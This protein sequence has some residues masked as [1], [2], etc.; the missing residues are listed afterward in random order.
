MKYYDRVKQPTTSTGTGN[1]TLG[2]A[3]PGYRAFPAVYAS[4]DR[5]MYVVEEPVSGQWELGIGQCLGSALVR[6]TPLYGSATTPVSFGAGTKYAYVVH[7]SELS[8]AEHMRIFG[9]GVDGDVLINTTVVLS[10]NADYRN[11]TLGPVGTLVTNG[12]RVRVSGVC[13][14]TNAKAKSILAVGATG[15]AGAAIGTAGAVSALP[16]GNTVGPA[17]SG[18][19]GGAGGTAA[20]SNGSS[21]AIFTNSNGGNSGASGNGGAGSGGAGGAGS[22]NGGISGFT[23]FGIEP[24]IRHEPINGYA[25]LIRGGD[26]GAGGGG[27]GGDGTA[28]GGGGA[29]G[30]GGGVL[31]LA[32]A[33]LKVGPSTPTKVISAEGGAGGAGGTPGAG[34]RGG[35]GGGA[36]AG[37]GYC[38]LVVGVVLGSK[39]GL[40]TCEGGQGG[41]AG[42]KTGTGINGI[43]G[44][45]GNGGNC[46]II[47]LNTGSPF[48]ETLG[49]AGSLAGGGTGGAIGGLCN[50]DV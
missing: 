24:L 4:T 38:H 9:T 30:N 12:W 15:G 28:G 8:A 49:S 13:D 39:A 50:G 48:T 10:Q 22:F 47:R 6:E 1:L 43:G 5:F 46:H 40:V 20:G 36:G 16:S 41:N 31:D 32:F 33:V 7:P 2:S 18:A 42:L 27:G 3:L 45:G 23:R 25:T 19:A 26:G 17:N 11:L 34:N 14:L 21:K 44:D 29:G 37:G 35:G